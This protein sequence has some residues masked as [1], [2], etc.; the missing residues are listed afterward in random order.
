MLQATEASVRYAAETRLLELGVESCE[1]KNIK[2]VAH[3]IHQGVQIS[4]WLHALNYGEFLTKAEREKIWLCLIELAQVNNFP[5]APSVSAIETP[6]VVGGSNTVNITNNY[7]AGTPF[8]DA[9]VDGTESV[10]SFPVSYARGAVWFYTVR[11]G[12]TDQRSGILEASWI[13]DGSQIVTQHDS[14][15]DIGDTTGVTLSV[16]FNAGNI[17]LVAT[18]TSSNWI[19]EGRRFLIYATDAT[20]EGGGGGG[21]D[22]DEDDGLW[23]DSSYF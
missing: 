2:K 22:L 16:D 15:N 1:T 17:R 8:Q 19:V 21:V 6:V 9:D 20:I 18:V 11:K 23:H 12:N 14:T 4:T 5:I 13:S 10:D 7:N 3:Q